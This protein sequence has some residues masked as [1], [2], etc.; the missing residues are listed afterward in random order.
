MDPLTKDYDPGGPV[1]PRRSQRMPW[2]PAALLGVVVIAGLG[3]YLWSLRARPETLAQPAEPAPP[4][5]PAAA[6]AGEAAEAWDLPGLAES[7]DFLRDV[8]ARLSSHPQWVSWIAT[9][10]LIRRFVAAVDEMARGELPS[11][12]LRFLSPKQGFPA[13]RRGEVYL[14]GDSFQ[15]FTWLA[16]VV[17]GVDA[18]AAVDLFRRLEP[19]L[20][21]AHRDLGYP[22]ADFKKTLAKAVAVALSTPDLERP[23]LL[24]PALRSYKFADPELEELPP[25]QK[26]M[27]RMGPENA[28]VIKRKLREIAGELDRS[29]VAARENRG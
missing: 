15:R 17:A 16:A 13:A 28:G 9:D 22:S 29:D 27:L 8:A 6:P 2:W 4:V 24:V 21:E 11:A 25:V 1:G 20:Q 14:D 12:Q 3:W 5:A 19:L 18:R 10:D 26:L 23:A 7:D